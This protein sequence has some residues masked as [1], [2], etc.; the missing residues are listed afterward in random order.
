MIKKRVKMKIVSEEQYSELQDLL[1]DNEIY[2]G[3]RWF[4]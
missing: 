2:W 4:S 3:L 1:F